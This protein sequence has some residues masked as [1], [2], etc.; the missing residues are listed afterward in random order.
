MRGWS[1]D[2][3]GQVPSA[4]HLVQIAEGILRN[5]L[6]AQNPDQDEVLR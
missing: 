2:T 3:T 6:R 1:H 4:V 5:R